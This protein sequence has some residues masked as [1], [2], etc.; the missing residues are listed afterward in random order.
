MFLLM[1]RCVCKY[2]LV[3]CVTDS[4]GSIFLVQWSPCLP[5]LTCWFILPVQAV[6]AAAGR[7]V[8]GLSGG[9]S[10]APLVYRTTAGASAPKAYPQNCPGGGA[11]LS[12]TAW[13]LQKIWNSEKVR[14]EHS[15]TLTVSLATGNAT[16][17]TFLSILFLRELLFQ[18]LFISHVSTLKGLV[19]ER[20]YTNRLALPGLTRPDMPWLNVIAG[21]VLTYF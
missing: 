20:W 16:M 9:S 2:T 17:Q 21:S 19:I 8:S 18:W 14:G 4:T 10:P 6:W 3:E 1:P 5:S 15:E 11:A 13:G 12:E 7:S